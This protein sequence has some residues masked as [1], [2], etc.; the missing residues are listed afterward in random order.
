MTLFVVAVAGVTAF[1]V[2]VVKSVISER[3]ESK[4]D[5]K[6]FKFTLVIQTRFYKSKL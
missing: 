4:D 6:L 1:A 5:L 3:F 2:V